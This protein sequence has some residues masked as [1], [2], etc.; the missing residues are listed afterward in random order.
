MGRRRTGEKAAVFRFRRGRWT[1][2]TT[3]NARTPHSR[4][5]LPI[6]A[7]ISSLDGPVANIM[8]KFHALS[9]NLT[10]G[11]IWLFSDLIVGYWV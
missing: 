9:I 1:N 6:K 11:K 3:V 7:R 8:I 5:K 10:L 2:G 4:K